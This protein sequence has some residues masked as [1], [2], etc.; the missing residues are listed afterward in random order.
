MED[1]MDFQHINELIENLSNLQKERD[2]FIERVD[3]LNEKASSISEVV[4]KKIKT[5]YDTKIN[6]LN[7]EIYPLLEE[8]SLRKSELDGEIKKYEEELKEYMVEKEEI[9]VRKELGEFEE[10]EAEKLLQKLEDENSGNFDALNK[11]KEVM[12]NIEEALES[13]V[14]NESI[15]FTEENKQT[16]D[17]EPV[18]LNENEDILEEVSDE[19]QEELP[20]LPPEIE[21]EDNIDGTV[22]MEPQINFTDNET[23]GD[24]TMLFS[25]P[26]LEIVSGSLAGTEFRVKMGTTNIGSDEDND[27]VLNEPL[28]AKKHAQ[29]TFGPDG[30]TIYDFNSPTGVEVNGSKV[31]EYLL[32]NE[33]II[34]IGEVLLKFLS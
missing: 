24:S 31:S 9:E 26:V 20:P 32:K 30:F 18:E 22:V 13:E 1:I 15:N 25:S 7:S 33:D 6:T 34:Q 11:L 5:D 28:V 4:Y 8:L 14:N 10:G 21:V 16:E 17:S 29:I 27:V 23:N 2:V 19:M 12:A 3:K